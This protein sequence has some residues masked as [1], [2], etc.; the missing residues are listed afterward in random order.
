[1][2]GIELEGCKIPGTVFFGGLLLL[3]AMKRS[4]S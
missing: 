1:M 4:P 3:W 2:V